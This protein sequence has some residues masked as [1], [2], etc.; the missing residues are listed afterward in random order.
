[1]LPSQDDGAHAVLVAMG[2]KMLVGDGIGP[3]YSQD[4]F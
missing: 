4:S 3:E 1:M 2:E